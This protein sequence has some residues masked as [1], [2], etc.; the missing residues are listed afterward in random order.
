MQA[1]RVAAMKIILVTA[2]T[3]LAVVFVILAMAGWI[4]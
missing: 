1:L 3:V 2:L 4:K